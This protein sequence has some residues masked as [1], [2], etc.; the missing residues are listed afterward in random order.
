M[1]QAQSAHDSHDMFEIQM[2]EGRIKDLSNGDT[3]PRLQQ[4]SLKL[5]QT[6]TVLHKTLSQDEME[7]GSA[8]I[9]PNE[10]TEK[11]RR[12]LSIDQYQPKLK[13]RSLK[14][15]R[16]K[17]IFHKNNAQD[18][19]SYLKQGTLCKLTAH[20]DWVSKDIALSE[21]D[22]V[23]SDAVGRKDFIPLHEISGALI[24]RFIDPHQTMQ[25]ASD[26][27]SLA[28]ESKTQKSALRTYSTARRSSAAKDVLSV[29]LD[30][31][32]FDVQTIEGGRHSGTEHFLCNIRLPVV[33][34]LQLMRC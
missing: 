12:G 17:T 29:R 4:Q 32:I 8:R 31:R 6:Y 1:S 26:D 21:T 22:F 23:I 25:R 19:Y 18:A 9:L 20:S 5:P 11:L 10:Q 33:A 34:L 27:E 13:R 16:T 24:S 28:G 2:E 14:N 15:A 3:R 7:D 30:S